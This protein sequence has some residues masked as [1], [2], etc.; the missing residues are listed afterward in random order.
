M[1][2]LYTETGPRY[3]YRQKLYFRM[4]ANSNSKSNGVV[5]CKFL[6]LKVLF[7]THPFFFGHRCSKETL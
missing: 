1:G 2:E 4:V 7:Y 6:S 3:S 5:L